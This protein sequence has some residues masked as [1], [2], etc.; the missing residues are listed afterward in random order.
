L[1]ELGFSICVIVSFLK[2]KNGFLYNVPK[3]FS[4]C[5]QRLLLRLAP[6]PQF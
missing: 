4:G 3:A 5:T 1:T 2:A 6:S